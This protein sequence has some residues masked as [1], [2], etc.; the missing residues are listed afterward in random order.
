MDAVDEVKQRLSI[1]DVVGRYVQLKRTGGNFKANCPFH[2]ERT[3][4]FVV[5]PD[6][7]VYHCFGCGEGGDMFTFVQR[8]DGLDFRQTLERLA[9]EAGVELEET[10]QAASRSQYKQTLKEA[11]RLAAQYYHVQLGRNQDAHRY[12]TET[13]ALQPATIKRFQLGYAP[14]QGNRLYRFL[15]Q[16]HGF[17]EQQLLDCGL[18]R[19]RRGKVEDVFRQ[20]LVVPFF[21]TS[22]QVIGFTGRALGDFNPKYLNTSQTQLFDKS[23]FVFGLYQAKDAVRSRGEAVVVEGNLDVLQSHQVGVEYVV[24]LSGTALTKQQMQQ[25]GRLTSTVTFAFDGD[26]AGIK[27]TERSL[28]IAQDVGVDL[29]IVNLPEGE[30]PDDLIRRAPSQW[31]QLLEDKHYVMDWL[32]EQLRHSYDATTATGKRQLT[33][34]A[35]SVIQRL[36]DPVEQ[37][38]Y[39]QAVADMVG[40]APATVAQKVQHGRDDA[41]PKTP[42]AS[43]TAKQPKDEHQTVLEALLSL[44]ATFPDTRSALDKVTGMDIGEVEQVIL[45]YISGHEQPLQV[46]GLPDGLREHANYVNILLLRGEQSYGDW[47]TLDR[48]VEAFSLSHRLNRLNMKRKRNQLSQAIAAADAAGDTEQRNR[49][50]EEYNQL[51]HQGGSVE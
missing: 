46:E 8:M 43:S 20:R 26:S 9:Q 22:G 45:E 21:D 47:A 41:T 51:N 15:S 50:L 17:S 37:E 24:A 12:V 38:H 40:A 48:Q 33:D 36:Q 10:Q 39:T 25:L 13:R 29:Y 31:Q 30:D 3:P 28:P 49:L 35:V 5:S 4:S 42:R 23:R 1:E 14:G 7:G 27:A 11:L 6:K 16:K 44:T 2:E 32:L 18:I 19:Y 34:R